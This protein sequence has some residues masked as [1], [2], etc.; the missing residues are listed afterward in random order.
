M[1][2]I[3]QEIP[4]NLTKKFIVAPVGNSPGTL[5]ADVSDSLVS[6]YVPSPLEQEMLIDL[7]S[8]GNDLYCGPGQVGPSLSDDN[9]E[10]L[11]TVS[12]IA[13]SFQFNSSTSDFIRTMNSKEDHVFSDGSAYCSF[14]ISMWVKIDDATTNNTFIH[15]GTPTKLE[16][17]LRN[18]YNP[19]TFQ[20]DIWFELGAGIVS[21]EHLGVK[22]ASNP[23]TSA[24][25]YH[26]VLVYD[27]TA[28]SL[29]GRFK[30][31]VNGDVQNLG[32]NQTGSPPDNLVDSNGPLCLGC[33]VGAEGTDDLGGSIYTVGIWKRALSENEIDSIYQATNTGLQ[34]DENSGIVSIPPRLKL[35]ELDDHPGSYSTI[36]RTGDVRKGN[37]ASNF[38]DKSTIVFSEQTVSFPSLL[39]ISSQFNL[40]STRIFGEDSDIS[41]SV[42]LRSHQQPN[43]LHY[44]PM[45]SMGPFDDRDSRS[46]IDFFM[47]GTDPSILPG[48]SSP[49]RSKVSIEIDITPA[50]NT[51]FTRNATKRNIRESRPAG[52]DNTGFMYYSFERSEWEQIGLDAGFDYAYDGN[53]I[54]G[55]TGSFPMQ[56]VQSPHRSMFESS[57]VGYDKIGMP[58][59]ALGAPNGTDYHAT[60]SQ[61]LKLS[62]YIS[63]PLLLEAVIVEFDNVNAQRLNGLVE[64]SSHSPAISDVFRSGSVR[65]IDNYV[66]FVYR[67]QRNNRVVDSS[68]D[69]QSTQRYIVATGSMTFWN[70]SSLYGSS[71]K[72]TPAFQY[73]WGLPYGNSY[74]LGAYTGSISMNLKPT[75]SA[76]QF[77]SYSNIIQESGIG[78]KWILNSWPGGTTSERTVFSGNLKEIRTYPES[79]TFPLSE[80]IHQN[81]FDD[82]R[83]HKRFG[84]STISQLTESINGA[85]P[86]KVSSLTEDSIDSPYLLLPTDELIFGLEAGIGPAPYY[87]KGSNLT[88]SFLQINNKRCKITLI[89]SLIKEQKEHLP[90]LNQD[91]SSN[92]IHEAVGSEAVLD[93][94]E[95]EKIGSYYGSYLDDIVAGQLVDYNKTSKSYL[96]FDQNA[97]EA[98]RVVTRS[99]TRQAGVTGSLQKFVSMKDTNERVYDSCLPRIEEYLANDATIITD[100]TGSITIAMNS[101]FIHESGSL[102]NAQFPYEMNPTRDAYANLR[103]YKFNSDYNFVS[104]TDDG[105]Y[106]TNDD[107]IRSIIFRTKWKRQAHPGFA[108]PTDV[109]AHR[110]ETTGS[111]AASQRPI[112][113][114]SAYRYGISNT[115]PQFSKISWRTNHYGFFRDI[116]EQRQLT[117]NLKAEPPIKCMFYSGSTLVDPDQTVSQ[118]LSHFA[119]SSIPYFD[120][121]VSHNRDTTLLDALE[122]V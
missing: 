74:G 9:P 78:V 86:I 8:R 103:D 39:P 102:L 34:L 108:P 28:N 101:P 83:A 44:S 15:K 3:S 60:S 110:F 80:L 26:I 107:V 115:N 47:S 40:Q 105:M 111:S 30:I 65:D 82:P 122:V 38:D 85:D 69:I 61:C 14:T 4:V 41:T 1:P 17:H 23:I 95:V 5:T 68:D 46:A 55:R 43:Y 93:Q 10:T 57:I 59:T 120:D 50:T 75:V 100:P 62:N 58:T 114:G 11:Q 112:S 25:W 31:Y 106:L 104:P 56:F 7:T 116:F 67:Q 27:K 36:R 88:G 92:S 94:F 51:K 21:I 32:P 16:F 35:R 54:T 91:L 81:F 113:S 6:Y 96:V 24:G 118:N 98:R 13:R 90:V 37:L 12:K 89:G 20:N 33:E 70:S 22:T 63:D 109:M 71:L 45:E 121:G 76:P 77:S 84:P 87:V 49:M 97:S 66:F 52:D 53:A 19:M 73:E 99:T 42:S 72:H 64:P 117:A 79:N 2:R 48:F 29:L 18:E 119:T